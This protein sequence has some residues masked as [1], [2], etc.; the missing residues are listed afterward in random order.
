MMSIRKERLAAIREELQGL[1]ED[2]LLNPETVVDRARNPNSSLHDHFTWDDTE[3]AAAFRIQ[4]A[5]AL[6]KRVRV[7]VVRSDESVVRV[8][9][10]TRSVEGKGYVDTQT[11]T[12]NKADH[13]GV[14]LITLAQV[15]TMLANLAAPEVDSLISHVDQVKH[16]IANQRDQSAA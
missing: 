1:I 4:E 9:S 13:L 6:I 2:G 12:V 16:E 7:E 10:F 8:P 15:R 14:V 11:I 3:A 5:R